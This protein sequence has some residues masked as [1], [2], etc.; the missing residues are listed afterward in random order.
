M[1]FVK[2]TADIV[3]KTLMD[4]HILENA[5][6]RKGAFTRNC[7]KLPFWTVMKLLLIN[8]KKTKIFLKSAH[9]TKGVVRPFFV[10]SAKKLH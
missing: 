7:G 3:C 4:P 5:R 8:I 1:K 9:S 6:R 2:I 10:N